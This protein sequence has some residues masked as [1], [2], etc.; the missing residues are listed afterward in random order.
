MMVAVNQKEEKRRRSFVKG[1]S[2]SLEP[3][4]QRGRQLE[5][6]NFYLFPAGMPGE[7]RGAVEKTHLPISSASLS[8]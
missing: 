2:P 8:N 5:P 6:K 7:G 1:K 4:W 3:R